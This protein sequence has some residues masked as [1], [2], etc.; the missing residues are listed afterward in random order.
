[1]MASEDDRP[2]DAR[3]ALE[4]VLTLDPKSPTALRQLGELELQ[5]G[6]YAQA[7]Q[8]LKI[9]MEVRPDDATAAY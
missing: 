2:S 6:D 5:A 8:H 7:S 3:K 4:K 1:M 9:A